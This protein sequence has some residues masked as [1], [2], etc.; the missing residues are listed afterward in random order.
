MNESLLWI[1]KYRPQTLGEFHGQEV[2]KKRIEALLKSGSLPHMMFAGPPGVGKSTLALIV[3]R[4]LFGDAWRENFLELNA[5][6]ARGIDVIRN[7]V[8]D[9]ARTKALSGG[10]KI[11]F[12]D[13]CDALTRE[14]Q[15]ALRRTMEM[16]ASSTRFILSCN[17]SSKIIDPIMSRCAVFRFK[18]LEESELMKVIENVSANEK[19]KLDDAA[20]QALIKV[21]H[22]DVRRVQNVLQS[23][24]S[25]NKTVSKE[26]IF[27]IVAAA[28]PSDV[29]DILT[30]ALRKDFIKARS[31]LLEVMVKQGISGL[32][33]V[34]QMSEEVWNTDVA[35]A[36]KAK[37]LEF[38]GDA[39][40]R[41]VEGADEFLQL[42]AF[43]ARLAR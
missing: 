40:F 38:C 10:L 25:V 16:Y 7:E 17:F 15:Q 27:E 18:P 1:E 39:E 8:K 20:K 5:S 26:M 13:E 3:A 11:I 14:A 37:I 23:C 22:G 30:L 24:A 41:M 42:E 6:D 31:K 35:D 12:L 21:S 28:Q 33:L 32:E 2:I 4:E 43:L 19:L 36:E 29:R 34:K 9:F